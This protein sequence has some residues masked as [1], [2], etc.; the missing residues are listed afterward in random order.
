MIR[1]ITKFVISI[2]YFILVKIKYIRS[3]SQEGEDLII[4]RILKTNNIKSNSLELENPPFAELLF[5][6]FFFILYTAKIC[7]ILPSETIEK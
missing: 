5:F 7:L 4:D 1:L 6:L 2:I 3:A